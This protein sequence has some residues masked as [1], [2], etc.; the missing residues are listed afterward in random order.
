[1]SWIL[2]RFKKPSEPNI[3]NMLS[4]Y[5]HNWYILLTYHH[6]YHIATYII[7]ILFNVTLF[8]ATH[9]FTHHLDRGSYH[10]S[11]TRPHA[12]LRTQHYSHDCGG[13]CS[14]GRIAVLQNAGLYRGTGEHQYEQ[15]R[16]FGQN[17]SCYPNWYQSFFNNVTTLP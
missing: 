12:D 15:T 6:P 8:N 13:F 1:M 10:G 17:W 16:S 4:R 5:L 11:I 2:K 9:W 3:V 7:V 14:H